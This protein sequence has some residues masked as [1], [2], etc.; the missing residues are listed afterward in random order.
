MSLG[1][2]ALVNGDTKTLLNDVDMI[3]VDN[4]VP[5]QVLNHPTV[6]RDDGRLVRLDGDGLHPLE[7]GMIP[8]RRLPVGIM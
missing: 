3:V 4:Q 5:T 7:G 2:E 8:G 6:V 1:A